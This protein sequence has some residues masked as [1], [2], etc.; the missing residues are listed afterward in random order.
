MEHTESFWSPAML[1]HIWREPFGK[2]EP[3]CA[4]WAVAQHYLGD[5]FIYDVIAVTGILKCPNRPMAGFTPA[6]VW[7]NMKERTDLESGQSQAHR[8]MPNLTSFSCLQA[9]GFI[10]FNYYYFLTGYLQGI[11][12]NII[13]TVAESLTPSS[14][15]LQHGGIPPNIDTSSQPEHRN[16]PS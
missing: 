13:Y 3:P 16:D 6:G 4:L 7:T 5:K 2:R 15:T 12:A 10:F 9:S 1:L 14:W 8:M 11:W